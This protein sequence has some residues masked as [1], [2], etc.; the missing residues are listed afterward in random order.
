MNVPGI[1]GHGRCA[2]PEFDIGGDLRSRRFRGF[3]L[4]ISS[5]TA[6]DERRM[7]PSV[8]PCCVPGEARLRTLRN[9]AVACI[10]RRWRRFEPPEPRRLNA[11]A[12]NQTGDR[13]KPPL[14]RRYLARGAESCRNLNCRIRWENLE[15][16]I[17]L[18][19]MTC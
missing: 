8:C 18:E 5:Q 9:A 14:P 15:P 6:E 1:V 12:V 3:S 11:G 13:R 7:C 16:A 2:L 4:R 10:E 19:P 17:G